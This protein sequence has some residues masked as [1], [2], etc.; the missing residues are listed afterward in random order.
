MLTS[1]NRWPA[2]QG[3]LHRWNPDLTGSWEG[4]SN[5]TLVRRRDGAA[6]RIIARAEVVMRPGRPERRMMAL[7]RRGDGLCIG[8]LHASTRVHPLAEQEVRLAAERAVALAGDAPL[9]LGGDFNIRPVQSGVYDEL[10]QR[11]GLA[12]VTAPDALDHLLVRNAEILEA[13]TSWPAETREIP[14]DGLSLRLSDHA[15]VQAR[16]GDATSSS[17]S[18]SSP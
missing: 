17:S 10:A 2:V 3:W 18:S 13:P 16:F 6:G 15:P 14:R 11:Y 8:N 5:L 4:G 9:I 12:P 1:R 7:T